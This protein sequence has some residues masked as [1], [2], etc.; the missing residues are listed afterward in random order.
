MRLTIKTTLI[1]IVS[2][3]VMLIAVQAYTAIS[4]SA[5]INTKAEDLAS[6]WLPSI[7][8]LGDIKFLTTRSR[9]FTSRLLL[10]TDPLRAV[11]PRFRVTVD[12]IALGFGTQRVRIVEIRRMRRQCIGFGFTACAMRATAVLELPHQT[13][14]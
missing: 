11:A 3:L 6:N 10:T 1:G 7:R 5:D 12:C 4:K 8:V 14:T 2:A 13:Q 9:L